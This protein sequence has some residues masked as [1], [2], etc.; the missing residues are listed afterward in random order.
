MKK[1]CTK[2][3]GWKLAKESARITREANKAERR[4]LYYSSP[5]LCKFCNSNIEYERKRYD[6]CSKSCS[7]SYNNRGIRRHGLPNTIETSNCINC[8]IEFKYNPKIHKGKFCSI[9]CHKA[10]QFINETLVKF[11]NGTL[12]NSPKVVKKCVEYI[13]GNKCVLCGNEG[14]HNGEILILQ[15]DHIDGNSDNN[16]P[17]NLRLLCPNCHSQTDTYKSRN[18]NSARAKYR[19]GYYKGVI[20]ESQKKEAKVK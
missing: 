17:S 4:R 12:G 9:P 11:N 1:D 16:C 8:N 7:A 20:N 19:R 14:I 2:T 3:I 5:K 6:F 15:L 13:N 18:K 10:H